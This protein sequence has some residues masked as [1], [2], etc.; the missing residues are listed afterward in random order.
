MHAAIRQTYGCTG[1]L[2]LPRGSVVGVE[3][4]FDEYDLD[5]VSDKLLGGEKPQLP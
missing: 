2:E 3:S 5:V 1:G 4:D